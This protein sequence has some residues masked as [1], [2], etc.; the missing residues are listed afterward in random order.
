MLRPFLADWRAK[1]PPA[2]DPAHPDPAPAPAPAPAPD[3]AHPGPNHDPDAAAPAPAPAAAVGGMLLGDPLATAIALGL[4]GFGTG[5]ELVA[6][7]L[8]GPEDTGFE[9][10]TGPELG[11]P[12]AAGV[13]CDGPGQGAV[14]SRGG[15]GVDAG[16]EAAAAA[17]G[18]TASAVVLEWRPA[19]CSVVLQGAPDSYQLDGPGEKSTMEGNTRMPAAG[20]GSKT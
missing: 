12:E 18:P 4:G 15:A 13:G 14:R 2:P 3:P 20:C 5:P 19:R 10:G 16:D 6:P 1:S 9:F 7:R 17:A 8:G 11:A